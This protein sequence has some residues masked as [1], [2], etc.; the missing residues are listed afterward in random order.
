[1]VMHTSSSLTCFLSLLQ[2][3]LC[4]AAE[5]VLPRGPSQH[6]GRPHASTMH[7]CSRVL[8]HVCCLMC[9][10]SY[11]VCC[12]DLPAVLLQT[13]AGQRAGLIRQFNRQD[14]SARVS[15]GACRGL[16]ERQEVD[17]SSCSR[18]CWCAMCTAFVCNCLPPVPVEAMTF[19]ACMCA[20]MCSRCLLTVHV[21][22]TCPCVLHMRAGLPNQHT[23]RQC[24]HQP[25]VCTAPGA[26]RPAVEPRPQQAGR[27][28]RWLAGDYMPT[29]SLATVHLLWLAAVDL[30]RPTGLLVFLLPCSYHCHARNCSTVLHT[31]AVS[32]LLYLLCTLLRP[33]AVCGAMGSSDRASSTT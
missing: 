5:C 2:C 19:Q 25:G 14:L 11:V 13:N 24:G 21:C 32:D 6:A 17:A 10:A 8:P 16:Q 9:P 3:P 7:P 4:P 18:V 26:V 15:P 1:M 27:T 30:A 33:S 23:C 22:C 31:A 12:P 20:R 28:E 29:C